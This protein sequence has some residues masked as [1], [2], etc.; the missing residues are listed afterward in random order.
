MRK[1]I[2]LYLMLL[3][4]SVSAQSVSEQE[5]LQ[6]ARK[7][8]QGKNIVSAAPLHRAATANPYKHLYLFNAENNGGFVIVSG[9][10]RAREILAYSEEGNLDYNQMPDNM[11]WW[12]SLYDESIAK[13]PADMPAVQKPTPRRASKVDVAPMMS[14]S[15]KQSSPYNSHC[16]SNC[17]TGCVPLAMAQI[18]AFHR[19]PTTLPALSGYS[20]NNGHY[21]ESLSSRSIDYSN[22]TADDAAWLVRYAGQSVRVNYGQTNTEVSTAM[23]P[24]AMMN[25]FGYGQGLQTI[26]REAYN[27]TDWDDLLYAELSK[28][29][30]FILGGQADN[31]GN[32]GHTFI[33][34]GY[35]QGYYAVNWGWGGTCNGYFAMSAMIGN[36][37]DYT[38]DMLACIGIS[39]NGGDTTLGSLFSM[40]RMEAIGSTQV[41][42]S[43]TSQDFSNVQFAWKLRNSLL[44]TGQY[45]F[46]LAINKPDNS[47]D[48]LLTYNTSTIEP[49]FNSYHQPTVNI[50]SKY[51]NGTYKI[52]ML[53]KQPDENTWH[54]CQ[55]VNWRYVQAVINGNT[56]TLTNYPLYD[57]PYPTGS[58]P[59][60]PDPT[61][62]DDPDDPGNDDPDNPGIT[63]PTEDVAFEYPKVELQMNGQ[64]IV[65]SVDWTALSTAMFGYLNMNETQFFDNF[66]ADCFTGDDEVPASDARYVSPYA[67]NY[68]FDGSYKVNN[69]DMLIFNLGD[70]IFGNHGKLPTG[71]E[72]E[73]IDPEYDYIA[74]SAFYPNYYGK[75]RHLIAFEI[76][77]E[78]MESLR[79]GEKSP[80]TF[81]R[82][83]RFAAKTDDEGYS[84]A[85]FR[86]L[87]VKVSMQIAW[88]DGNG[89]TTVHSDTPDHVYYNLRGQ[90][91]TSPQKGINIL[92]G[93][94]VI[95]R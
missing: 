55:G 54:I 86:Y 50:S 43:S 2:L 72:A 27:S 8:L 71:E 29:R 48:L 89:I 91:I 31:N 70:D 66:W 57:D 83:I 18:M 23:V 34:H 60:Y 33:C 92:R 30:P 76:P 65:F 4:L 25:Q 49:N 14:Y 59:D 6:K 69:Y 46:A 61:N 47:W 62:P 36:G 21:L 39:P 41:Y 90:R 68:N 74:I 78:N 80:I 15:W 24:A 53:F 84:T 63:G 95:I 28:G 67:Y 12:L 37:V 9:D 77:D 7:F 17:M 75:G 32:N 10:S 82:W 58:Y 5:A 13:I 94:K 3:V 44:Q 52:T 35:S 16:P 45:V 73:Y 40:I 20:D 93:K 79:D 56:L 11:K 42:R 1:P 88:D 22:L 81:T 51:G 38:H 64:P 85:P 26:Y 87:W 19:Y